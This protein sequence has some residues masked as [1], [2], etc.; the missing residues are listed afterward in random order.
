MKVLACSSA[1]EFCNDIAKIKKEDIL[2]TKVSR[3]QDNEMCVKIENPNELKNQDMLIV[4]SISDN[5]N[6]SLVELLFTLDTVSNLDVNSIKLLVTYAGY[7]RQDRIENNG[8]SFSFKIVAKLISTFN[9]RKI[10]LIDIHAPQTVGFFNTP[11]ENLE[12]EDFVVEKIKSKY[13]NPILIS[14]DVGNIKTITSIADKMD[15]DYSIAL[16]YR[17]RPN[18]SKILSMAGENV[19]GRDCIIVDDIIDSAGTICNVADRVMENG[20]KSITAYI[21]HPV[22]SPKSFDRIKNS[23]FTKIYIGNT[24]N[25]KDK[26]RE[27]GDKLEIFSISDW[28]IEK[29][30]N[31]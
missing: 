26:I 13:K 4:Q 21:T 11:C 18:E 22:L 5:V 17:P 12:I 20:A 25:S 30:L 24:I 16:K 6:D 14:P 9:I 19:N 1:A 2:Y 8:E 23:N 15:I 10:Y 31:D 29:I 27:I 7:S 3:F 28:A